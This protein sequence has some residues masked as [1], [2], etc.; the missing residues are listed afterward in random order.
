VADRRARAQRLIDVIPSS[1]SDR[2]WYPRLMVE[3]MTA[4]TAVIMVVTPVN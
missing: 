2:M 3:T 1:W 4:L